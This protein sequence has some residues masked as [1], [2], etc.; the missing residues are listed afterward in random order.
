MVVEADANTTVLG[1]AGG[2]FNFRSTPNIGLHA[3]G[4]QPLCVLLGNTHA[5]LKFADDDAQQAFAAKVRGRFPLGAGATL[6]QPPRPPPR[7]A[8]LTAPPTCHHFHAAQCADAPSTQQLLD[9][10]AAAD[11]GPVSRMGGAER[12]A[13]LLA[14]LCQIQALQGQS[15][16]YVQ[17][18]MFRD[19]W[20]V[21]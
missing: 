18:V 13:A 11:P 9:S 17:Q 4:T 15:A 2:I 19:I 7:L 3:D 20:G 1:H 5:T 12:E 6:Q 10:L 21:F 8:P 16:G 14:H